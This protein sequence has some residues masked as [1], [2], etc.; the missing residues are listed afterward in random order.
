MKIM[1]QKTI[2][3]KCHSWKEADKLFNFLHDS[4]LRDWADQFEISL[5]NQYLEIK[6]SM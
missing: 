1:K 5:D 6:I 2:R 3:I 4:D